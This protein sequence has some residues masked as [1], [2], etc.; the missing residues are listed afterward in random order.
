MKAALLDRQREALAYQVKALWSFQGLMLLVCLVW[1]AVNSRISP[2]SGQDNGWVTGLALIRANGLQFGRDI[3]YTYGP[4]GFLDTPL[5]IYPG[6]LLAGMVFAIFCLTV[7]WFALRAAITRFM[8]PDYAAVAATLILV[9]T[10]PISAFSGPSSVLVMGLTVA[11]LDY[12]GRSDAPPTPWLPA[13]A[14]GCAAFLLQVK[15]N[16]GVM[17]GLMTAIACACAP[18]AWLRRS[19]ESFVALIAVTVLAWVAAGQSL[20]NIVSYFRGAIQVAGG[21]SSALAQ[22]YLPKVLS[23]LIIFFIIVTIAVY[24]IRLIPELSLRQSIGV[25]AL[26]LVVV[27][28]AF[29]EATVRHDLDHEA[30]FYVWTIPILIWFIAMGRSQ[31]FRYVMAIVAVTLAYNVV[32]IS[33]D[34]VRK[35]LTPAVESIASGGARAQLLASAQARD[36]KFYNVPAS[37]VAAVGQHPLAMDGQ[38]ITLAWAYNF[39]WDAPPVFQGLSAYTADL[40]QGNADWLRNSPSDQ[41]FLRPPNDS[42]EAVVDTRNALWDPPRYMLAEL[43]NTTMVASSDKWLLLQKSAD[44]CGSPRTTSTMHVSAG[45][46]I[47]VPTVDADQMVTASF[48]ADGLG[49]IKDAIAAVW[50]PVSS[51]KATVDDDTFKVLTGLSDGP[52]VMSIPA[53]I[54]WPDAFGGST[55]YRQLT[56]SQ[57]GTL[58]FSVIDVR[59]S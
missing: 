52:M 37:M 1:R 13:F 55:S 21:Y 25:V 43:C 9:L 31:I 54:D 56:F 36:Q 4:W 26:C 59:G 47:T 6:Q 5:A 42:P 49:L 18:R 17:L 10:I 16:E 28:L 8:V 39:N 38:E 58:T 22:D 57:G 46:T 11:L 53:S 48:D 12:V 45:Q 50:K 27:Y 30:D 2:A 23:Y 41:M 24:I 33:P 35:N 7:A 51:L 29:K 40:D 14:A 15:F 34:S 3:N 19:V 20:G 44:H 32:S